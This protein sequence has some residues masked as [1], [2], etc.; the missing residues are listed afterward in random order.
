VRRFG[1]LS[2]AGLVVFAAAR[3]LLQTMALYGAWD[4]AGARELVSGTV[5][6]TGWLIQSAGSLLAVL[7]LFVRRDHPFGPTG[8]VAAL[9]VAVSAPLAGHPVAVPD[10]APVAVVLDAIHVLSV[11]SWLGGLAV[12]LL[13]AIPAAQW[14]FGDA[15]YETVRRLFVAFTPV[16][17]TS[18][19]V[20]VLSG[21]GGALL[22]LGGIA[23]LFESSY[24][25]LLLAK[26][27]IVVL[28]AVLGLLNW[29]RF[30]P[31]VASAPGL[32]RFRVSAGA[33]L[34]L[35]V[36]ALIVTAVLTATSPPVGGAP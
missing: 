32:S 30:V 15:R 35:G 2:A 12:L 11:G 1:L 36:I 29:R 20:L 10:L 9:A 21:A 25:R 8:M 23:P 14:I 31:G 27:G 18:A 5:W 28:V 34:A 3:L 7:A 13:V 26:V 6:G 22:Q 33:E 19:G 16:A 17:L 4:P 24:G